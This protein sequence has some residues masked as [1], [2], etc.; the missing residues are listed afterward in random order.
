V[1]VAESIWPSDAFE[2]GI[3]I[4][5]LTSD[6]PGPPM[7][8]AVFHDTAVWLRAAATELQMAAE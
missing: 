2:G 3:G 5:A 6:E 8:G 1:L 7:G 4:N